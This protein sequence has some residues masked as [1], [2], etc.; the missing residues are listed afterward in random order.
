VRAR[1]AA[2]VDARNRWI[3]GQKFYFTADISSR[4]SAFR[5]L[6]RAPRLEL[7]EMWEQ[8]R[9]AQ[10]VFGDCFPEIID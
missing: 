5:E 7:S 4:V 1:Y 10:L 8:L 2:Q 6:E 9:L 3:D